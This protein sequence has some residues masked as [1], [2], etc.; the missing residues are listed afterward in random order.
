MS[1]LRLTLLECRYRNDANELLK[2]QFIF[3]VHNK[4][5]QDHLL[6]EIKETDNSVRHFIRPEKLNQSWPKDRCWESLTQVWSVWMHSNPLK[7]KY[8][9]VS[10][11]DVPME[12]VI[13]QLLAKNAIDAVVRTTLEKCVD[14]A[15]DPASLSQDMTQGGQVGP[16]GNGNGK[17]SHKCRVYEVNECHDDMED[18]NEQVQSLFYA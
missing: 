7:K 12:R 10:S 16:H 8:V 1:E 2:D 13:V 6:N 11:V 9:T 14:L 5:I 17:C 3:G 15:R 18:L 4:E